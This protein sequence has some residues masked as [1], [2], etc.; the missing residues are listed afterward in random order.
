MNH[1]DISGW[2]EWCLIL[3]ILTNGIWNHKMKS[4]FSRTLAALLLACAGIASAAPIGATGPD[5]FGYSGDDIAYNLRSMSGTSAGVQCDDCV[6]GAIGLGFSF[7]FYGNSYTQAYIG[8]NGFVTFSSG[9][10]QGCCSSPGFPDPSGPNNMVAGLFDDLYPPQGGFVNYATAGAIGSREFIV[11]YSTNFC[12]SSGAPYS[13]QIILH[14]ST[15]N[16]EF[17]YQSALVRGNR[18][19]IGIENITGTIGLEVVDPTSDLS[20]V[21]QGYLISQVP[22]PESLALFGLALVAL[23]LSRRKAKQV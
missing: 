17:Q 2:H 19:A 6:S 21:R 4:L 1:M 7:D 20:L 18:G 23:G 12:C 14:E 13:F 15:N 9:Q 10:S 3:P 11:S 8:S 16:I 22:E 5:S